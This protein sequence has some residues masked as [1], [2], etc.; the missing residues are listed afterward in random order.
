M[1]RREQRLAV[2]ADRLLIDKA[3]VEDRGGVDFLGLIERLL[4][5]EVRWNELRLVEIVV[6]RR[7]GDRVAERNF[8]VGLVPHESLASAIVENRRSSLVFDAGKR[9]VTIF[10]RPF[11]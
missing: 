7:P 1:R 10:D 5:A 3:E 6:D 4:Q 8:H 9:K 11:D 2:A